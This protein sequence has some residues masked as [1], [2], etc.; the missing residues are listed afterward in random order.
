MTTI[1]IVSQSGCSI[2]DAPE[3]TTLMEVIK[4]SGF[5]EMRAFCGGN[6]SCAT[7]HVYIDPNYLL[8]LPPMSQQE[9]DHLE[10]SGIMLPNS[11]L[12]CQVPLTELLEGASVTIAP[13]GDG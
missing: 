13:E 10:G 12:S 4:N 1:S 7:C 6:C 8:R 3:S 2:I 9:G 5:D 11:R